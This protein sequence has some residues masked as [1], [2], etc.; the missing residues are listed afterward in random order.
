MPLIDFD[1]Q[2]QQK[3][4]QVKLIGVDEAGRGPL[5]GPICAAACYI[6]Q[7]LYS[8]PLMQQIN[9]SKKLTA[10][11]REKI[12]EELI[13]LPIIYCTGFASSKQI[14]KLN[15]LQATFFAMRH[16]L[17]KFNGQDIFVLVDGNR[18]ISN[19]KS[20]QQP[21]VK[22]DGTSLCVA[23]ASIIAKVSRDRFMDIVAKKYPEY[24]FEGHKG[25]GT[26]SH[27]EAIKKYGPCPEHRKT[28]EPIAS[29]YGGLFGKDF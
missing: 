19:L 18:F 16:A 7:D 3:H 22:G 26:Q 8:H 11:K 17:T 28:F 15:I 5:A 6:P 20:S 1:L 23:A 29:L 27:I 24:N 4:P 10:S 9:D 21:I 12:F 2:M 25:Y 13:K 14:D